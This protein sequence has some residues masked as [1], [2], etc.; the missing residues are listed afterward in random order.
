MPVELKPV[1]VDVYR[2]NDI[3]SMSGLKQAG[4]LGIFHKV[5]QGV[6][7][8]DSRYDARREWAAK[9][10]PFLWGG[11]HFNSELSS[12][13]DQVQQFVDHA[14]ADAYTALAMDWEGDVNQAF[15]VHEARDFMSRLC[16]LTKRDPSGLWI[17]GGNIPR[18]RITS[19]ADFEF[20]GKFRNWHCQYGTDHPN[21]SKAWKRWDLWQYSETGKLLDA[22][23][24]PITGGL[25]DLNIFNGTNDELRAMW[26]PGYAKD[27]KPAP[28]TKPAP[29]VV[30]PPTN[31][32]IKPVPG[33]PAIP[34]V[35]NVGAAIKAG[36]KSLW[37]WLR[38]N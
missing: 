9:D 34:A 31:A 16:D 7:V 21:V 22:A 17:Y 23:G 33:I 20:F 18:E 38:K 15:N 28:V 3:K 29:I 35:P 11:Y 13:K 30:R 10:G 32:P 25:V 8:I 5:S 14:K 4:I 12:I 6:S 2:G 36:A 19:S 27:Y 1:I 37:E 26:A 24:N